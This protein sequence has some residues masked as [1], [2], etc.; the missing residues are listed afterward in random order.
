MI[1]TDITVE[2]H[3]EDGVSVYLVKIASALVELNVTI[4]QSDIGHLQSAL[5]T[6]WALGALRLGTSAG[7]PVY[8]CAGEKGTL[9]VLIGQDDET[10]DIALTLP[11]SVIPMIFNGLPN[12]AG[13]P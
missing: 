2:E 8:W 12:S 9:S 6:E 3:E 10:W 11:A 4:P 5:R 1:D 7:A 13:G